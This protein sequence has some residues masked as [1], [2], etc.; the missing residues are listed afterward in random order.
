MERGATW[1]GEGDFDKGPVL[2]DFKVVAKWVGV[3][4]EGR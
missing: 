4:L 1:S 2:D 3:E